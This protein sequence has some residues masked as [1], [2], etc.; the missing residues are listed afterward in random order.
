MK[1]KLKLINM[2]PH[3]LV[4]HALRVFRL[5]RNIKIYGVQKSPLNTV[6][7]TLVSSEVS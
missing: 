6:F 2:P 7:E 4:L 3:S 1:M 5:V